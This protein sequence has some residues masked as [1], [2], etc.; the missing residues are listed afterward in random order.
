MELIDKNS[1][2]VDW[3][4]RRIKNWSDRS[5]LELISRLA[6]RMNNKETPQENRFDRAYGAWVGPES[7]E[8]IIEDIRGSR[9]FNRKIEGL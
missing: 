5:K 9:T 4:L 8:E 3:Y 1:K 7:A 2:L 6:Q